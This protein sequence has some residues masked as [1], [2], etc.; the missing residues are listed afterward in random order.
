LHPYDQAGVMPKISAPVQIFYV[1]RGDHVRRG[2][3]LA[4]LENRDLTAAAVENRGLYEQAEATYRSTTAASL[5]EEIAKAQLEVQSSKEALA[6]AQKLFESRKELLQQGAL[7]RR[8][9]DEASVAYVQARSQYDIAVK[10]LDALQQI[11][12]EAQIKEAQGQLDA[13]RGR[14]QGAEAQLAYSEI[15]SPIDGVITD[16]PT[17]AGEMVGAGTPLLTVMDISR[18]VARANVP[19]EQLSFVKVGNPATITSPD[20]SLELSGKVTV[21]SPALD[22]NSTTAEVWVQALNPGERC[23]PG[24]TVRVSILAETIDNAV[25]IP[26]AAILPSQE[27]SSVAFVVGPDSLAHERRIEIGIREADKVQVLKGLEPGEQVVTVGGLGLQD[28][29]Q[30]RIEKTNQH[31]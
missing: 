9:V 4:V 15:R 2:Q 18:V 16:R 29:T 6:A 11:G 14:Y 30:V 10:H 8:L 25:A 7:A 22:P 3:L 17:Y 19:V 31:D 21:V 12:K 27:G 5:P 26:P 24:L 20:S 1:S 28:K 23:K 13:A